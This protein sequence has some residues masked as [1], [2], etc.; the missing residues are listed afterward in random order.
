M[1]S[2]IVSIF[3]SVVLLIGI[4]SMVTPIPGGTVMI[5]A[6]LTALICTSPRARRCLQFMRTRMK[7][8][9]KIMAW[10]ENAVGDRIG[11]VGTAL[12]QTRP[13]AYKEASPD[14]NPTDPAS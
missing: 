4:V 14:P 8:F 11:I 7:W 10:V 6:S 13:Q 3:A 9:D 1:R 12:R 2:I 5:A